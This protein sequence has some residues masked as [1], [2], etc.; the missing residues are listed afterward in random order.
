MNDNDSTEFQK[1]LDT[2]FKL[3]NKSCPDI[4]VKRA[5]WKLLSSFDLANIKAAFGKHSLE[6]KYCPKP[7]DIIEALKEISILHKKAQ[8]ENAE[9]LEAEKKAVLPPPTHDIDVI[10]ELAKAQLGEN[11]TDHDLLLERHHQLIAQDI[12]KGLIRSISRGA[13]AN[14]AVNHC[15][16]AGALTGS[17]KGSDTW[18]CAEHARLS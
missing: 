15:R 2:N 17:L 3:Y 16:K 18:Y 5:W 13:N 4:E 6:S 7:A 1:L 14:C 10:E 8:K 9:R 12:R 11:A